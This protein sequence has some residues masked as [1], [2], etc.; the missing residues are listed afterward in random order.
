MIIV[1]YSSVTYS[2]LI[3]HMIENPT[4]QINEGLLRHMI[5]NTIRSI[6]KRFKN[7]YGEELI[8]AC[9]SSNSWRKDSFPYYK[10]NR[11]EKRDSF[12]I[13]WD[14]FFNL[15]SSVKEE[16]ESNFPY[17]VVYAPRSEA[18]DVIAV[19][20]RNTNQKVLIASRD[21]DFI[22]LHVNSNVEQF[23]PITKGF[24]KVDDPRKHLKE[25]IIRGDKSD[26]IPNFLSPDNCFVIGE[27]QKSITAKKLPEWMEMETY[28]DPVMS[29][30]YER[31]RILIDFSYIPS[32]VS[33]NIMDKYREQCKKD[34]S[35]KSK[36]FNYF[37]D[38]RLKDL[39]ENIND[40]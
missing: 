17:R 9:D 14:M 11:K 4:L 29:R 22:Q 35:D 24:M 8:I 13:D 6:Y 38:K 31:N 15:S 20:V 27:R 25:L 34:I 10:A 7:D 12:N 2:N 40:F 16:I 36:I 1:D 33:Q 21:K 5:L 39:M 3:S 30:N 37:M 18:D 19:I 32:E 28:Q 26:G 23:D